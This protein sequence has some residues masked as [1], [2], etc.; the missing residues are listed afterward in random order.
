[1]AAAQDWWRPSAVSDTVV[2]RSPM[3]RRVVVVWDDG[4]VDG[5]ASAAA[6]EPGL[7]WLGRT[8][9]FGH[10]L[11]RIYGNWLHGH[12]DGPGQGHGLSSLVDLAALTAAL[13]GLADDLLA[14][15]GAGQVV[16]LVESFTQTTAAVVAALYP[17]AITV[18]AGRERDAAGLHIDGEL[19]GRDP[20]AALA[21]VLD[22]VDTTARGPAAVIANSALADR[23]V[24]VVGVNRSGTTLLHQLLLAHPEMSGRAVTETHLFA[25]LGDLWNHEQAGDGIAGFLSAAE[26]AHALRRFCDQL[27]TTWMVGTEGASR[28]FVERTPTHAVMLKTIASIYPDAWYVHIIRDGRDVALS[29]TSLTFGPPTLAA[30][31][32]TWRDT[33]RS[34]QGARDHLP[35][36]HELRY[37]DL[38]A[39]PTDVT[40]GL[41]EWLGAPVTEELLVDVQALAT[42]RYSGFEA[43]RRERASTDVTSDEMATIYDVAGGLLVELGYADQREVRRGRRPFRRRSRR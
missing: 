27:V 19:L 11:A 24:I 36:F 13:R 2:E 12:L 32:A 7:R 20:R 43:F 28:W 26:F 16:V 33:I 29:S 37:E 17:D 35:R 23:L 8:G 10:D 30:A 18:T 25:A 4:A 1:M 6:D 21:R 40:R 22:G 31:A 5:L 41:F 42:T 15:A 3:R 9:L 39:D 14:P 34:V 38:V